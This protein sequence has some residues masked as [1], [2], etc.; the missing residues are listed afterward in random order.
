MPWGDR[1][2]PWGRGAKTGGGYGYCSG[3]NG[4]GWANPANPGGGRWV[5]M[6]REDLANI[7]VYG[8]WGFGR[9]FGW[10][11]GFGRGRGWGRGWFGRGFGWGRFFWWN[12]YINQSQSPN[13]SVGGSNYTQDSQK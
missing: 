6:S 9:G 12:Q 5:N 3:F 4:P 13:E 1:T 10:G 2:G 11:R 8:G 7:P